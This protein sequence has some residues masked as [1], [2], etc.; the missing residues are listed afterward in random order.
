[1]T[2]SV[3]KQDPNTQKVQKNAYLLINKYA[4]FWTYYYVFGSSILTYRIDSW[5]RNRPQ[6]SCN[7]LGTGEEWGKGMGAQAHLPLHTAPDLWRR[8]SSM[9]LNLWKYRLL[10]KGWYSGKKLVSTEK[11]TVTICF[12]LLWAVNATRTPFVPGHA[13]DTT[14]STHNGRRRQR[15]VT[16]VARHWASRQAGTGDTK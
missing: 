2:A 7:L 14:R 8:T 5:C 3:L 12:S 4:F 6:K 13:A 16:R 15:H 11:N 1:M 9:K 10:R